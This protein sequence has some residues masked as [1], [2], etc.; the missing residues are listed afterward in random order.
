MSAGGAKPKGTTNK[1]I[2]K[3]KDHK[4]LWCHSCCE[5]QSFERNSVEEINRSSTDR[6]V[7]FVALPLF[8]PLP[9]SVPSRSAPNQT[10]LRVSWVFMKMTSL[11]YKMTSCKIP[12]FF[13]SFFFLCVCVSPSSLLLQLSHW[14]PLW[15]C[16]SLT[17]GYFLLVSL[18]EHQ[19]H[20][21]YPV[22]ASLCMCPAFLLH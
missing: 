4:N 20:D 13:A 22:H 18:T 16:V 3:K 7:C 11:C 2:Y 6:P 14:G 17:D 10:N 19:T 12:T 15:E 5:E 8:Q 1:N 9:R 21:V